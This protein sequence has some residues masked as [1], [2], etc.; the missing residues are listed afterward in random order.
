MQFLRTHR[1]C[2]VAW[3]RVK[4]GI[5]SAQSQLLLNPS[6]GL[7]PRSFLDRSLGVPGPGTPAGV[8]AVLGLYLGTPG[9]SLWGRK[10]GAPRL[11]WQ[12]AKWA[13]SRAKQREGWADQ[14]E[15]WGGS[16]LDMWVGG[17]RPRKT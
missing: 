12:A 8:Q 10:D 13:L 3:E 1:G 5:S 17:S 16:G 7:A 15:G 4:S 9:G 14:R 2:L 11:A 6:C